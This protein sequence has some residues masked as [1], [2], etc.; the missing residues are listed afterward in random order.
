MTLRHIPWYLSAALAITVLVLW[1]VAASRGRTIADQERSIDY[2]GRIAAVRLEA[3]DLAKSLIQ[4]E[5]D[6][7]AV[8]ECELERLRAVNVDRPIPPKPVMNKALKDQ[9]MQGVNTK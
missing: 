5:R 3:N 1:N 7:A 8:L 6:R 4:Q 9:I 2:G